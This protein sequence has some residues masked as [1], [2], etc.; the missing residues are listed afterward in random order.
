ME[1]K[2]VKTNTIAMFI[3]GYWGQREGPS[4]ILRHG[5]VLGYGAGGGVLAKGVSKM[6]Q[7]HYCTRAQTNTTVE[8]GKHFF[9]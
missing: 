2:V 4:V 3:A 5:A 6:A 1:Q 9:P 8:P 7:V